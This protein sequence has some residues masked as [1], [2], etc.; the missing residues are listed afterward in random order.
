MEDWI[1]P[2]GKTQ[3]E[4]DVAAIE[5]EARIAE[6]QARETLRLKYATM[7]RLTLKLVQILWP[8]LTPEEQQELRDVFSEEEEAAIRAALQKLP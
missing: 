7:V 5:K 4:V 6:G 8:K 2:T 3:A 1:V